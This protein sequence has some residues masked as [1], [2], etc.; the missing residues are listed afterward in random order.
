MPLLHRSQLVLDLTSDEVWRL[1]ASTRSPPSSSD[2]PIDYVKWDH[3][4]DLLEAGQRA[5]HGGAPAA[6]DRTWRSTRCSTISR[7]RTRRSPGSPAPSGGGRIDL[8]VLERVQRF[9]T[10]DMTDALARQHI[11]RWTGQLVA[12]EYLG[13]HVSA[14][15]LPPDRPDPSPRLPCATAFFGA[16]GIEWDLTQATDDELERAGGLVRAAQAAPAAAAQRAEVRIPTRRSRGA[17]PRR[18]RRG[19]RQRPAVPR[20]ARRVPAQPGMHASGARAAP[21]GEYRSPVGRS[22]GLPVTVRQPTA[23]P[24]RAHQGNPR[25]RP[26][27]RRTGPVDAHAGRRKP[28]SSSSS[29]AAT[30]RTRTCSSNRNGP[31]GSAYRLRLGL[32]PVARAR[33]A[34]GRMSAMASSPLGQPRPHPPAAGAQ[35]RRDRHRQAAGRGPRRGRAAGARR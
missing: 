7:Q 32:N 18:G 23:G 14:P 2:L 20:P 16:F 25:H 5:P 31:N 12:P 9:W 24:A 3:N 4:R 19:P 22:G 1:P 26:P 6:H 30:A 29:Y 8:G 21:A 11:Q 15:T 13:A 35:G 34:W 28:P 33:R 10:S 27:A 17:R